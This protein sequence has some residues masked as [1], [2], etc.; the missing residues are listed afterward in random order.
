MKNLIVGIA[1][2]A[3][4]TGKTTTMSFIMSEIKKNPALTLGLT[5]IGYDGEGF[6]NITGLP[7]PRIDVWPGNVV[8]I[9][10][11]CN[12]FCSAG[13]EEIRRTDIAT[14]LGKVVFSRVISPGKVVLAGAN[15]GRDLRIVLELLRELVSLVIVDGA[16][17]R[18]AP[19]A[20]ADCLILATGAARCTD[21]PQLASES[22][23]IVDILSTPELAVRGKVELLGSV[24][25]QAGL[26]AFMHKCVDADSINI[27]GVIS[28]Q[29]LQAL[30]GLGREYG[31]KGKRLIF[32]DPIKLLLAGEALF[33]RKVLRE[34]SDGSGVDIG[35]A[36]TCKLLAMTV[37]PYYPKY[38]YGRADYQ[39]AYVDGV[40]LL[41]RVGSAVNI[42]CYDVVRQGGQGIFGMIM[43]YWEITGL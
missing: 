30:V 38:R 13:L 31:L 33:V 14:P 15:K 25:G 41:E 32:A 35:V 22:S 11:S 27:Q 2:T 7:K 21:I 12:R 36:K 28:L 6:D 43:D 10:E 39:D 3:K 1:G 42:P 16:I 40:E 37:N 5:S 26:G 8:A 20:E 4:N 9:A 17:N 19:M 34:L 23:C 24:L 29:Y 18:I